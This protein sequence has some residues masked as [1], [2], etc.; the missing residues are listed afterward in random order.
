M[1]AESNIT[2]GNTMSGCNTETIYDG[3]KKLSEEK[4]TQTVESLELPIGEDKSMSNLVKKVQILM[5][6]QEKYQDKIQGLENHIVL[7][8]R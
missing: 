5:E 8:E 1:A 4:F 7:L 2:F 6:Y 3:K